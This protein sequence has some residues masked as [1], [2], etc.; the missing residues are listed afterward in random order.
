MFKDFQP[1]PLIKKI[2]VLNNKYGNSLKFHK[3]CST[4]IKEFSN[5]EFITN[6]FK[7]Y[8][9]NKNF[10]NKKW[11]SYEIPHLVIYENE[12]ISIV[13]NIFNPTANE[14]SEIAA[15]LIHH[16]QSFILSSYIMAGPGYHTIEFE[17]EVKYLNENNSYIL[18]PSKSFL[19]KKDKVNILQEN[20]P[21][22]IFNVPET[23][24]SIALWTEKKE[25]KFD[26]KYYSSTHDRLSYFK[27][28]GLYY[29]LSENDFLTE[30]S[31]NINYKDDSKIHI[32][33]ICYFLQEFGNEQR[34]Y[35]SQIISNPNISE[36]WRYWL[37]MLSTNTKIN[38][39]LI[40]N[41]LNT[42]GN[43]MKIEDFNY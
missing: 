12:D 14:G 23:T 27:K 31:R 37:N 13:Y 34:S 6:V 28:N 25:E 36:K 38:V 32:Q 3:K 10:L 20:I 29:G 42:L 8:I 35:L 24:I 11:K 39:P 41:N 40:K 4:V 1:D 9:S 22:L 26:K 43:K 33:S 21:H 18:K 5:P 16:H 30:V 15:H 2:L 7:Q 19:H 17:K